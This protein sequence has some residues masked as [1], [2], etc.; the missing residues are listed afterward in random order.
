MLGR[1]VLLPRAGDWGSH[2]LSRGEE[3]LG[4]VVKSVECRVCLLQGFYGW[5]VGAVEL[6]V[7]GRGKR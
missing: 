7:P 2:S 4:F 3:I 5:W 6:V 1:A